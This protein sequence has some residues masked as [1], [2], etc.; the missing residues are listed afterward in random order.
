VIHAFFLIA[1]CDACR[2]T[3]WKTF[4]QPLT[5]FVMAGRK[6]EVQTT[7]GQAQYSEHV[8]VMS[9]TFRLKG[10]HD[11]LSRSKHNQATIKGKKSGKKPYYGPSAASRRAAARKLRLTQSFANDFSLPSPKKVTSPMWRYRHH[12]GNAPIDQT[13][14]AKMLTSGI[15]RCAFQHRDGHS[16]TL[17]RKEYMGEYKGSSAFWEHGDFALHENSHMVPTGKQRT[18][19]KFTQSEAHRTTHNYTQPGDQQTT[20]DDAQS[21]TPKIVSREKPRSPGGMTCASNQRG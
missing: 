17:A 16:H 15:R 12:A 5:A 8:G 13:P 19:H 11:E 14:L 6:L 7:E 21:L 2:L 18:T 20:F 4:S 1:L 9:A 3:F 10:K